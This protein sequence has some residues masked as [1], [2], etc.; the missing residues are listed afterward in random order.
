[1]NREVG[2][3]G[4][5]AHPGGKDGTRCRQYTHT[6]TH[7]VLLICLPACRG[8]CTA[9]LRRHGQAGASSPV[10]VLCTQSPAHA[11]T[12]GYRR[13]GEESAIDVEVDVEVG[14]ALRLVGELHD[15]EGRRHGGVVAA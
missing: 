4:I 10:A 9:Q 3:C 15:L 8:A 12:L 6:D 14:E 7:T 2:G 11:H 1:V 5:D 13:T